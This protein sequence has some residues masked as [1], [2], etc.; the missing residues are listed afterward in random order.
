[1]ISGS[2]SLDNVCLMRTKNSKV[3]LYGEHFYSSL[4]RN[5][6]LSKIRKLYTCHGILS[7]VLQLCIAATISLCPFTLFWFAS[8]FHRKFPRLCLFSA[9]N[10]LQIFSIAIPPPVHTFVLSLLLFFLHCLLCYPGV[11]SFSQARFQG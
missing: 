2:C 3:I 9:M 7:Y 6:K 4:L 11:S 8:P 10:K 5:G 1:M